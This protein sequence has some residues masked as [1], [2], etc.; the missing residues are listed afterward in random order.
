MAAPSEAQR[1]KLEEKE[2]PG[3][4]LESYMFCLRLALQ[5][6]PLLE[7]EAIIE[8]VRQHIREHSQT[9]GMISGENLAKTLRELGE[10]D[11]LA[12]KYKARAWL[13]RASSSWSPWVM[14]RASISWARVGRKGISAGLILFLGYGATLLLYVCA[15]LKYFLSWRF[16]H[17]VG[18]AVDLVM[19]SPGSDNSRVIELLVLRLPL[20]GAALG[21]F[22]LI[23]T[24][25][26]VRSLIRRVAGPNK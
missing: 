6:L 20:L 19:G 14:L 18:R 16:E 3:G 1:R 22:F 25:Y 7:T 8:E 12:A 17:W 15:S 24:T 13:V 9:G 26:I 11:A 4:R 21:T 23:A 10:P 5:G 2:K